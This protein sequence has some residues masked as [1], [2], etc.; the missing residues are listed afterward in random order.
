MNHYDFS[1]GFRA[2]YDR[3]TARFARGDATPATL[4][5]S[6]DTAFLAANGITAQHLYDYVDDLAGYG[7]PSYDQAHAIELVRRDYFHN[8]QQSRASTVTLD[9]TT[10]P[11]KTAAVRGISW[12]PRLLPK[13]R[14]KLRG[15]LPP[16]LMYGCGGDRAFFKQH[17][18][19]PHEFLNLV[20]RF[21][22]DD[23]AIIDW[24]A[25][26]QA[27]ATAQA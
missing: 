13:A 9:P 19:H 14:A 3:A 18:I 6:A 25:R 11:A 23:H 1:A 26:R 24:V 10:L 21:E 22:A 5:S 2:V 20:W 7:E 8:A 12:L 15:E 17:H 16:A 4:L 27:L